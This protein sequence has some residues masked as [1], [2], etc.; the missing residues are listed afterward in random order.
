MYM[1]LYMFPTKVINNDHQY[2]LT[3]RCFI[4]ISF[5]SGSHVS[6]DYFTQISTP[7][8]MMI[9]D[10]TKPFKIMIHHSQVTAYLKV[11]LGKKPA[12]LFKWK[13]LLSH[14]HIWQLL[15]VLLLI[16]IKPAELLLLNLGANDKQ[17]QAS[18]WAGLDQC[19][20]FLKQYR[21]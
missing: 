15:K 1:Y 20:V 10:S 9:Y 13:L 5:I 16:L 14:I 18:Y 12:T 19:T 2:F 11:W 4:T 21:C 17:I 8:I 7:G 3:N 6:Q